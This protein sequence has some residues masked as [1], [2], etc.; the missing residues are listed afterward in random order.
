MPLPRL[1]AAWP[2]P[3]DWWG[4]LDGRSTTAIPGSRAAAAARPGS[5]LTT[6]SDIVAP[7]DRPGTAFSALSD[8]YTASQEQFLTRLNTPQIPTGAG[9]LGQGS[10]GSSP[11]LSTP[12]MMMRPGDMAG[13]LSKVA[14]P[15]PPIIGTGLQQRQAQYI[16]GLEDGVKRL[17]Q[18]LEEAQERMRG[19]E[20]ETLC[21]RKGEVF[22]QTVMQQLITTMD[23][24]RSN[25]LNMELQYRDL[26]KAQQ[27]LLDQRRA[28]QAMGSEQ[29]TSLEALRSA[30]SE[31][32][33]ATEMLI[34]RVAALEA[35]ATGDGVEMTAEEGE[36][37][38]SVIDDVFE[39]M[40][41]EDEVRAAALDPP[42][43]PRPRHLPSPPPRPLCPYGPSSRMLTTL[44]LTRPDLARL[45]LTRL[46]LTRPLIPE[47]HRWGGGGSD[48]A[49]GP[50]GGGAASR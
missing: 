40:I 45:D 18:G 23:L 33:A 21:L 12:S 15:E 16:G 30:L 22:P 37:L 34:K 24:E 48:V 38:N 41:V 11:R 29:G 39:G 46:D 36:K 43:F 14:G 4:S 10:K 7:R 27:A 5:R 20:R 17:R 31:A 8:A 19:L 1:A 32:D 47:G 49:G 3:D 44:I 26:E 28:L 35:L 42:L 25:M 2:K 50:G 13:P 6:R 9:R